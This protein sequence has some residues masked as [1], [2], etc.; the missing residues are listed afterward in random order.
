M[1]RLVKV[2]VGIPVRFAPDTA[3]KVAGNLPSGSVP[4]LSAEASFDGG[5]L[6]NAVDT[7]SPF[8]SSK[9]ARSFAF[10]M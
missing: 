10:V 9:E 7:T 1:P 5:T 3:G 4:V 8:A 6:S 2:G